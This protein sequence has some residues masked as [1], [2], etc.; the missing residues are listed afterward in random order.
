MIKNVRKMFFNETT[1]K[2]RAVA[3]IKDMYLDV[4]NNTYLNT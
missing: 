3:E 4:P 2:I 1:K